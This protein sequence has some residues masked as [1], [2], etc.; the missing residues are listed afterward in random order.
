M[1]FLHVLHPQ[2]SEP[3]PDP[4]FYLATGPSIRQDLPNHSNL[5]VHKGGSKLGNFEKVT[6]PRWIHFPF[7]V[8]G[9]EKVLIFFNLCY[10]QAPKI[11]FPLHLP[12]MEN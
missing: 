10:P 1:N 5:A 12:K 9:K 6:L 4:V 8:H 2:S 11:F 7:W 3:Y